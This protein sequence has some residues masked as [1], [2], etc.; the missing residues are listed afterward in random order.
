MRKRLL[1]II[2]ALCIIQSLIPSYVYAESLPAADETTSNIE[3]S[4]DEVTGTLTVNA[5]GVLDHSPWDIDTNQVKI[6]IIKNGTTSIENRIFYNYQSLKEVMIE[7]GVTSIG[8]QAFAECRNLQHITI[9]ASVA[10]MEYGWGY[11][12]VFENCESLISAG[13]IGGSYSI[14]YGWTEAIPENAFRE[15][16]GLTS[17]IFPQTLQTIGDSSFED[18]VNLEAVAL[19]AGV[20]SIGNTAFYNCANLREVSMEEGVTSIGYQAFAECRNLQHITIPASVAEMEYG[21]GYGSVFENCES[22]ISAGPIGGS[23]SIEYGWT[24]AIPENAFRECSGLT[25]IFIPN[26]IILIGVSAFC[27]CNNLTN[28]YYS[29]TD[30]EWADILIQENNEILTNANVHYEYTCTHTSLTMEERVEATCETDGHIAYWYCPDCKTYFSDASAINRITYKNT[31]LPA[32]GH[33]YINGICIHCHKK[34]P[35]AEPGNIS[36]SIAADATIFAVGDTVEFCATVMSENAIASYAWSLG[37]GIAASGKTISQTF[38][39]PGIFDIILT[40]TDVKGNSA[41][42]NLS[43]QIVDP[44]DPQSGYTEIEVILCDATT[45]TPLVNAELYFI[46]GE[47][48]YSFIS[49]S[50]GKISAIISNGTYTMT[51]RTDNYIAR[52]VSITVEGGYQEFT[53]SLTTGSIMGGELSVKEMTMDEIISAGINPDAEGN[54]HVY[55]F[56]TT[57]TFVAGVKTYEFPYVVYKNYKGEIISTDSNSGRFF[58]LPSVEP[59]DP[60]RFGIFPISEKFLL[61][62]Y[63]EAKWLKEMY[64]VE[65]IVLNYSETDTLENVEATLSLPDGLSFAEMT[66]PVQNATQKLGTI[67]KGG[68]AKA[69]WYVVGDKAGEYHLT[70]EVNAISKPFNESIHQIYTTASPIRVYAGDALHMTIIADDVAEFGKEYTV[71]YRLENVSDKPLYNISFG[72]TGS[73][74]YKV[75]GI[76]DGSAEL[77][78]TNQDYG[79]AFIRKIPELAPG[80]YFELTLETTIWFTSVLEF[81][82]FSKVGA[83]VD[84][85]YYL[86]NISVVST[87]ESTTEIPYSIVVNRTEK[88]DGITHIINGVF[89]L[90]FGELIPGGSLGDSVI[91]IVGNGLDIPCN[92]VKNAKTVL[93]LQQGET[94]HNLYIKIDDG[95]GTADSI[96]NDYITITT[97]NGAQPVIDILNG[98]KITIESGEVSIQAK[99]IGNTKIKVGI[100]NKYGK[101]EKEWT[102]DINIEDFNFEKTLQVSQNSTSGTYKINENEWSSLIQRE[103]EDEVSILTRNPFLWFDSGIALKM[104]AKT[105]NSNFEMNISAENIQQLLNKTGTSYLELDGQVS[106][107]SLNRSLLSELAKKSGKEFTIAARRLSDE[108]ATK[109]GSDRPTYQFL[110]QEGEHVISNFGDGTVYISIPY[111]LSE[112]ETANDL[113]I[114]H[115]YSDGTIEKLDAKYDENTGT[116]SFET[117]GFSYFRIMTKYTDE[118]SGNSSGP[119]ISQPHDIDTPSNTEHIEHKDG[120]IT[121]RKEYPDGQITETTTYLNGI[122]AETVSVPQKDIQINIR[123]PDSVESQVIGIP[124]DIG[125]Q[126]GMLSIQASYSDRGSETL[127]GYYADHMLY[128][129]LSRTTQLIVSDN[130]DSLTYNDVSP[131]SWYSIPVGF[132]TWANLMTGTSSIN[133]SPEAPTT[134]GM[135]VTILYRLSDSPMVTNGKTFT[136]VPNG[137]WYTDAIAWADNNDIIRGYGN[138]IFGPNDIIT[139][140]QMATILYRYSQ[141][142]EDNIIVSGNLSGFKDSKDASEWAHRPLVWAVNE[143]IISGKGNGILDPKASISRAE[144]AQMLMNYIKTK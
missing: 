64:Q 115:I 117:T 13:P 142:T 18:C 93:S 4:F 70:A 3:W 72:I 109:L 143:S 22:L 63:G 92:M 46:Q 8:Y 106:D 57:L 39:Q 28:V 73:E 86:T 43:V 80:G 27:D 12:S 121:V 135:I 38:T 48:E 137:Q 58:D 29:G 49:D 6:V 76:G 33:T 26:S 55:E 34:E 74:Q 116:V 69:C 66:G 65:L 102:L 30:T 112:N 97:S 122:T 14:E 138:G 9:P 53:F 84:I 42:A 15:C 20:T 32:I 24:E 113:Y 7:E 95:K 140:E 51:G 126:C 79:D 111:D 11:G 85:A 136:D 75:I 23:Y 68:T 1:S 89:E 10:E 44:K 131:N 62:I 127:S 120:S 25:S 130:L 144:V 101:Q 21:W 100:E 61:V 119:S 67:D 31:I 132:M 60:I 103:Y 19:P 82:E 133:F 94:D 56:K 78:I 91:E 128:V 5:N 40:V 87:G 129:K 16:S 2:L 107:L 81:V 90:I 104:D 17:V 47:Q 88:D 37:S 45:L 134:R 54:Q 41:K 96:Y 118:N 99:G 71:K 123:V 35:G 125:N 105:S 108:E 124:I 36:V 59:G 52:T 98:S 77:E 50:D 114:E 83:F 141:Y 110:I 139:R